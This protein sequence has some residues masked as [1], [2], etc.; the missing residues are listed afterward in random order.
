M[1]SKVVPSPSPPPGDAMG[2]DRITQRVRLTSSNSLL[3]WYAVHSPLHS[4]KPSPPY[5]LRGRGREAA[6][7]AR[8]DSIRTGRVPKLLAAVGHS[9]LGVQV[10]QP[11]KL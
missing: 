6:T 1:G 11:F 2:V 3:R 9:A 5:P 4:L 10:A 8:P 7:Q